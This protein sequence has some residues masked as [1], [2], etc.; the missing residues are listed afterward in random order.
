[1][2]FARE[3]GTELIVRSGGHGVAGYAV[4]N[5]GIVLDLKEMHALEIDPTTRTAWAETGLTAAEYT[6]AADKHGL[7]TGFGDTGS[8]GTGGALDDRQRDARAAH[9]VRTRR[10]PRQARHLRDALL[11]RR[12]R[13]GGARGRT[14]PCVGR[15]D[16]RHGQAVALPGDVSAGGSGLPPDRNGAYV[17]HRFRRSKG[18]GYDRRPPEFHGR[19]DA[20]G[21][22][23]CPWRRH[24]PGARGCHRVR[25]PP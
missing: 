6:T 7:A 15:P 20:R 9:A 12:G 11:R 17:L 25:A 1:I 22:A 3:S 16:R 2:S 21:A 18:R 24:G 4:P 14:V 19:A 23:P 10:A 8:V 5:G 13:G